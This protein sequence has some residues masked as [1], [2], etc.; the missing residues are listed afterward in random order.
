MAHMTHPSHKTMGIFYLPQNT[1]RKEDL[2]MQVL[3]K[4]QKKTTKALT[5]VVKLILMIFYSL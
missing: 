2:T 1:L 3:I 5:N 4:S